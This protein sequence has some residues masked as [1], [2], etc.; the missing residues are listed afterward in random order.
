[1]QPNRRASGLPRSS[2]SSPV[3]GACWISSVLCIS[4]A[5][6]SVL[7][8]YYFNLSATPRAEAPSFESRSTPSDL[9]NGTH[10]F[11]RTVVL[12]SFD[13]LRSDYLLRGLTPHLTNISKQGIHA[14]YMKPIFPVSRDGTFQNLFS[15]NLLVENQDGQLQH[16]FSHITAGHVTVDQSFIIPISVLAR[17]HFVNKRIS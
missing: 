6:L 4:T 14:E 15:I 7:L 3:G 16:R 12:V 9:S 10:L 1:M 2:E 17:I 11:R 13:G 8:A 5:S